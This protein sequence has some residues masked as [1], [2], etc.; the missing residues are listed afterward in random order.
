M[1]PS[2]GEWRVFITSFKSMN[3][4]QIQKIKKIINFDGEIPEHKR[5]L[6]RLKKEYVKLP[7]AQRRGLLEDLERTFNG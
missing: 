2:G 5:L 1:Y 3:K 6:R 7:T 4:K